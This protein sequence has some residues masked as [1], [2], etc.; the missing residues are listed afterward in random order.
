MNILN[1]IR[2]FCCREQRC[3]RENRPDLP[4]RGRMP[5]NYIQDR[6]SKQLTKQPYP[7]R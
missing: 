1:R 2:D 6:Q 3:R 7:G 4:E 5:Y